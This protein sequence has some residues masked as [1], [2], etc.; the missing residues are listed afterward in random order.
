[1]SSSALAL[2]EQDEHAAELNESQIVEGVALVAHH[3]AA[4]I[5]SQAK[6]RSTFYQR[7]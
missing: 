6:S 4:E 1:L 7:L 5:S 2:A 3:E